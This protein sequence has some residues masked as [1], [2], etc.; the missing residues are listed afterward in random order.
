MGKATC[1]VE[2]FVAGTRSGTG[3]NGEY[4]FNI[5]I[6]CG[7]STKNEA[8]GQ[9]ENKYQQ[10]WSLTAWGDYAHELERM[11]IGKGTAITARAENPRARVYHSEKSQRYEAVIEARLWNFSVG[12]AVWVK[13]SLSQPQEANCGDMPDIDDGYLSSL[14]NA[15]FGAADIPF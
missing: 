4:F 14:D 15:G 5:S 10:W 8:T 11:N 9:Y 3:K 13:R 12:T 2:G 6:A 1:R 7:K